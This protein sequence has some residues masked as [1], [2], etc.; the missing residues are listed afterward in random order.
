MLKIIRAGVKNH[1]IADKATAAFCHSLKDIQIYVSTF[2][3]KLLG[4]V[5]LKN[6]EKLF[7]MFEYQGGGPLE[8]FSAYLCHRPC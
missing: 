1:I 2:L 7:A 4:F 5:F 8:S 3:R 6:A